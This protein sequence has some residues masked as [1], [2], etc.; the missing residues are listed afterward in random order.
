MWHSR[1]TPFLYMLWCPALIAVVAADALSFGTLPDTTEEEPPPC[2][3]LS[4]YDMA[5][6]WT[7]TPRS[8]TH[9]VSETL[10]P[11]ACAC[12][13]ASAWMGMRGFVLYCGYR[14]QYHSRKDPVESHLTLLGNSLQTMKAYIERSKNHARPTAAPLAVA[15]PLTSPTFLSIAGT[16]VRKPSPSDRCHSPEEKH[17]TFFAVHI[18]N[19]GGSGFMTTTNTSAFLPIASAASPLKS[20][21]SF[22]HSNA[23]QHH[24]TAA[25]RQLY[26]RL[27]LSSGP[28][29]LLRL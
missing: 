22:R 18:R 20:V 23:T 7:A 5:C 2:N 13:C 27:C 1:R 8:K 19:A 9:L 14:C 10:F 29:S 26:C 21:I 11:A 24:R 3:K 25:G 6:S 17:E 16:T 4:S 15:L 28:W 12:E